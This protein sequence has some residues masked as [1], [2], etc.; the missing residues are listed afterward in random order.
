MCL[1]AQGRIEDAATQRQNALQSGQLLAGQ[2]STPAGRL[3]LSGS[4]AVSTLLSFYLQ[5]I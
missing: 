5:L 2:R 4:S 1:V 3:P